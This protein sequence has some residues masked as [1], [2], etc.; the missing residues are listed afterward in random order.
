[1]IKNYDDNT[2]A[3][4]KDVYFFHSP[5]LSYDIEPAFQFSKMGHVTLAHVK[6]TNTMVQDQELVSKSD[7]QYPLNNYCHMSDDFFPLDSQ[8]TNVLFAG[9]SVTAGE[10]L[11]Y[12]YAWPH[13]LYDY[14][15]E[16]N[17][18]IGPKHILGFPGGNAEKIIA[19]IFK[20]IDKFGK[21]DYI[22]LMLPD[23]FRIYTAKE[24]IFAPEITYS[25]GSTINDLMFPFQGMYQYQMAYRN[26]EILCSALNIKLMGTS[27]EKCAN[28]EMA[29]L[30]FKTYSSLKET[31]AGATV[32]K[33]S[34]PKY[35][36]F[37]KDYYIYGS[38]HMH[39][40][41]MSHVDYADHF[42]ER[43]ENDI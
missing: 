21:P 33:M 16:K 11:P 2:H 24:D 13:H 31:K 8:N 40:G 30:N 6:E 42:I 20:Y 37:K 1:M 5:E 12:G 41:L 29:K 15:K 10:Y 7:V 43:L 9:C 34:N 17:S 27:W 26:L 4:T 18:N 36:R 22:F 35:K 39:P 38:D 19:N 32:E 25:S 14:L 3:F 23:M 28:V